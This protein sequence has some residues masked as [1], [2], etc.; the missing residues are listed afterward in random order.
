MKRNAD[1]TTEEAH[2]FAANQDLN[3]P[4]PGKMVTRSEHG[5]STKKPIRDLPPLLSSAA[6]PPIK[7][8]SL[9]PSM[10]WCLEIVKDLL[11]KKQH[12]EY[13]WPF[14]EPVDIAKYPDYLS[15]IK[16]PLDLSTIKVLLC[17]K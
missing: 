17:S 9:S 16:K 11:H 10:K 8:V 7:K 13:A 5:L 14:Y 12:W 6:P 3:D 15:I 4:H 1:T 2:N